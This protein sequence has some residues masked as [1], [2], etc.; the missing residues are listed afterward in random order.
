MSNKKTDIRRITS[1]DGIIRYVKDGKLHNADGPAVIYPN[2][3]EEYHL[4][5]FQYSKE[6]YK[7]HKKEGTGLPFYKTSS[8]KM[9]H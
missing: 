8:G 6:D 9:R 7:K 4:N 5:G 1:P 2:G 3:K